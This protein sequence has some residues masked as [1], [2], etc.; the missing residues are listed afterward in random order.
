[1]ADCL[2]L[3]EDGSGFLVF[4]DGSGDLL[5]EAC[6]SSECAYELEDNDGRIL[7]ETGGVLLLEQCPPVPPSGIEVTGGW[8]EPWPLIGSEEE[9]L[10]I[11]LTLAR[12]SGRLRVG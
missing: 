6:V 9:T 5:L 1:M 7:L 3:L 8:V 2:L 4:E 10:T 11:V 12:R